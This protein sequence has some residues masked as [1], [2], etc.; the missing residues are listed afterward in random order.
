MKVYRKETR[1][2]QDVNELEIK[3]TTLIQNRHNENIDLQGLWFTVEEDRKEGIEF[4]KVANECLVRT[5]DN[6][7]SK[8]IP[9]KY[10]PEAQKLKQDEKPPS[11]WI[12]SS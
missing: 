4:L 8:S 3:Q 9:N 7:H 2:H 12:V 10:I 11:I 1:V 6:E 5:V